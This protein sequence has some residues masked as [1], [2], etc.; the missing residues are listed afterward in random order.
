MTTWTILWSSS[1]ARI[2]DDNHAYAYMAGTLGG[3]A[4]ST[5]TSPYST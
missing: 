3:K 1:I 2:N 4:L 5:A